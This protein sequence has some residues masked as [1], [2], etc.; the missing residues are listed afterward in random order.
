M[1]IRCLCWGLEQIPVSPNALVSFPT[2][3][4]G[5]PLGQQGWVPLPTTRGRPA[6]TMPLCKLEPEH[7]GELKALIGVEGL[8]AHLPTPPRPCR[9]PEHQACPGVQRP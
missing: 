9:S 4:T 2:L 8:T 3:I 1:G 5:R 6:H 7:T